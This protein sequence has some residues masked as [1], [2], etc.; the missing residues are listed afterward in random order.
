MDS[1]RVKGTLNELAEV[2]RQ[3][4][5]EMNGNPKIQIVGVAQQ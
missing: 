4:T 3:K 5:G 2:A 1:N